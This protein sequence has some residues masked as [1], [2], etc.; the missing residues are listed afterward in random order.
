MICWGVV[1][2]VPEDNLRGSLRIVFETGAIQTRAD[3]P[4]GV[5]AD[6]GGIYIN[7]DVP[8]LGIL[9]AKSGGDI[10]ATYPSSGRGGIITGSV[11]GNPAATR[12]SVSFTGLTGGVSYTVY[13]FA[14]TQG[15]WTMKYGDATITT[16]TDLTSTTQVEGLQ[17]MPSPLEDLDSSSCLK[18]KNSRLPLSAKGTV[19]LQSSGNGE[20]S[21]ALLRC[22]AKVTAVFENQYGSALTLYGFTNTFYHMRPGKGYVVPNE[23]DFPVSWASAGDLSPV[24]S[25]LNLPVDD[26]ATTTVREDVVT[27]TWYVFPSIGP[28]T[29][30]ISFYLD[31]EKT[32]HHPYTGLQVHDD[33]ARDIP[34]LARNQHLTITTRISK[35]ETVSFNFEVADWGG[36]TETVTFN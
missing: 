26:P 2:C 21:L 30:D 34:Q 4:D 36:K 8:D 29:C 14:N 32:D 33:H 9:V 23:S 5:V 17:F 1:S 6:G 10:V 22:A 11:E 19:T 7:E 35:G 15:L 20:I 12:T 18:V 13:A 25:T 28:Y 16:L 24:E 31:S 3:E 27:K